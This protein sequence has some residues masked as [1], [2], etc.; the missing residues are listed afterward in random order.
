MTHATLLVADD[1]P[2]QR[3]M[4]AGFLED[5]GHRVVACKDGTE[6]LQRIERGGIDVCLSDFRMPGLTGLEL[7]RRG[8]AANPRV[9]FVLLT[10]HGSIETAVDAIRDGAY[11]FLVKP[12][13]PDLL[14]RIVARVVERQ[15]LTR[16]VD[17][18]RLRLK[19]RLS[20]DGIVARSK[21]MQ[22]VLQLVTRAAMSSATIL[23]MG[24]SGTGKELVANIIHQQSPR[25]DGPF[26]PVNCAA[27]PEQ[28]LEAELFG[29]EKGAVTGADRARDGLFRAAQGGTIFLDEIGEMSGALQAKMLRV[30]QERSMRPVGAREPVKVDVRVLC[31]TNRDL[32]KDVATGR[33]REDL[34]YRINVFQVVLPPLRERMDD[35]QPLMDAIL[36]RQSREEDLPER[37]LTREAFDLLA[38]YSFPGNVREL[39]NVLLRAAVL[40]RGDAIGVADL[41]PQLAAPPES[42]LPTEP[43]GK[44][45]DRYLEDVESRLIR[46]ALARHGWVQTRAAKDLGLHEKVLRYRMRKLGIERP[47][48]ARQK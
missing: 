40:C 10:A 41:P 4:L 38:S 37:T 44:P 9:D 25:R 39:E 1:D 27:I 23:L 13:D 45:L 36:R 12:V 16:E 48:V 35:L 34:F 29:H 30:L 47:E 20:I 31:A 22:D 19:E 28:L 26:L 33:F 6:A 8:R 11:D 24:E 32:E 18:L 42:A 7:L 15:Q 2:Q 3:D 43:L 5:L 17:A 21:R 46:S 14:E